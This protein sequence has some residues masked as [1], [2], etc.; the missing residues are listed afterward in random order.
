MGPTSRTRPSERTS[1]EGAQRRAPFPL[2]RPCPRNELN[3]TGAQVKHTHHP[4][5]ALLRARS[6]KTPDLTAS[7]VF[8]DIAN[9][10]KQTRCCWGELM[11]AGFA[12][13]DE[14]QQ[15][16][17]PRPTDEI[18]VECPFGPPTHPGAAWP[19]SSAGFGKRRPS[20]RSLLAGQHVRRVSSGVGERGL[21][22]VGG[23]WGL[24]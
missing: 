3:H 19:S 2:F 10:R 9:F 1:D 20:D 16:P 14:P 22:V 17:A 15:Q 7:L 12:S 8:G 4:A 23:L 13:G 11:Q 24:A 5:P 21:L 18:R 6:T